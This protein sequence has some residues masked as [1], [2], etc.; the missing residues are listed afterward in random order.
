MKLNYAVPETASVEVANESI[1]CSSTSS[2]ITASRSS[3]GDAEEDTW[4]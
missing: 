4:E 2:T 1:V 3:Y